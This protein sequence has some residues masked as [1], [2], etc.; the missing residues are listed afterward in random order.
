[1]CSNSVLL[2]PHSAPNEAGSRH[3]S[4]CVLTAQRLMH[5]ECW[6]DLLFCSGPNTGGKTASLKAL[7]LAVL[8]AK[9]GMFLPVLPGSSGAPAPASCLVCMD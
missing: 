9:A 1:M 6:W 7:G 8:M 4:I 2:T 5:C 3:R